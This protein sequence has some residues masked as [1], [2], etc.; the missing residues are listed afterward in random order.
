MGLE[1]G[2]HPRRINPHLA[3]KYERVDGERI[4]QAGQDELVAAYFRLANH[5]ARLR[6]QPRHIGLPFPR[7]SLPALLVRLIRIAYS[8]EVEAG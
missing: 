6:L 1:M 8:G 7:V 4:A 5:D 2:L 3:E